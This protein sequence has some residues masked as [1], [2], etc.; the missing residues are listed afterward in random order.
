VRALVDDRSPEAQRAIVGS[1]EFFKGLGTA[2]DLEEEAGELVREKRREKTAK[3]E[4][5]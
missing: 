4:E 2:G 5:R 1:R 3:R